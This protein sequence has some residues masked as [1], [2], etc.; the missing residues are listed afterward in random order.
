MAAK[1]NEKRTVFVREYLVDRNGTRAAIAA[2]YA[3]RSASVTSCRMLRN[4][5]VQAEITELTQERL[6]RLEVTAD[7]VLR[8]LAKIAFANIA[9]YLAVQD[10]GSVSIDLSRI[11]LIEAAAIADLKIDECLTGSGQ[12]QKRFRRTRLKLASKTTA[13]ELLGKHLKLWTDRAQPTHH[14]N[15]AEEI[16]KGRERVLRGMS[17]A[18]LNAK[19]KEL[20]NE[21][22]IRTPKFDIEFV[23]PASII[24]SAATMAPLNMSSARATQS[25]CVFP[26]TS[27]SKLR[28]P[29]NVS[30]VG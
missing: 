8:E 25:H 9:D 10:D 28:N 1:S 5:K 6:K 30:V 29:A 16:R 2:G 3:S 17:D 13:L 15:L 24:R 23:A 14:V 27:S 11:G 7:N 22:Q 21:L 20:E 19:I 12:D 26:N 4:V 18:E